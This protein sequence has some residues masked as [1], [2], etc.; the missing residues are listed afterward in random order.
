[1]PGRRIDDWAAAIPMIGDAIGRCA[2]GRTEKDLQRA[3]DAAL[4]G[5]PHELETIRELRLSERDRVDIAVIVGDPLIPEPAIIAIEVK[6][7]APTTPVFR[8]IQRYASH[9]RV[10]AVVVATVS[11]R[12]VLSLPPHEIGGKPFYPMHIRRF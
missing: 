6:L 5:P 3:L 7:D 11:R 4:G 12:L 2:G 8:Q 1:M 9:E 10:R